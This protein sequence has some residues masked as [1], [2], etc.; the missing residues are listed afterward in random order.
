MSGRDKPPPPDPALLAVKDGLRGLRHGLRRAAAGP[1][2]LSAEPDAPPLPRHLAMAADALLHGAAEAAR[3]LRP[4]GARREDAAFPRR[5]ADYFGA[6]ATA[7]FTPEA[8]GALKRLATRL[9]RP[10]ALLSE[11]A[12]DEA[13]RAFAARGVADRPS[14][15]GALAATCAAL[16]CEIA[17]RRPVRATG[18]A[19]GPDPPSPRFAQD[20]DL[21]A[22]ATLALAL[23]V[24]TQAS[25]EAPV[26]PR[27]ALEA[28]DWAV[29]ARF[30]AI[31]A[32]K[33]EAAALA[34]VF[35]ETLPFLP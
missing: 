32:A 27:D 31:A 21:Y 19:G 12:I 26:G 13:G 30:E 17:R 7:E 15:P 1:A 11:R 33:G 28:A 35:A 16:A 2:F 3:A 34:R 20:P 29:D 4:G 10:E 25:A 24:A 8:Y 6:G 5:I 23:G 22:G 18:P 14:E 9:G